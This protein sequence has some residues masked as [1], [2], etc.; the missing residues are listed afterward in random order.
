MDRLH[1]PQSARGPRRLSSNHHPA[2]TLTDMLIAICVLVIF[3][4]VFMPRGGPSRPLSQRAYC[5]TNLNSIGKGFYAYATEN[6][7]LFPSVPH[8]PA[9]A[10]EV[11][12][13]KYAPGMIGTHRGVVGD[14][15]SGETTEADIE[16]STTRNLWV[17]VRGGD[18]S[19]KSF[20]CPSAKDQPNDEDNPADFRDF[21]S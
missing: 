16:M 6:N 15:K 20:I 21:R 18:T 13:V 7:D 1:V 10:D 19:P 14:P 3:A 5:A 8:A 4:V 2:F 17:L 11:G 12:R 9:E